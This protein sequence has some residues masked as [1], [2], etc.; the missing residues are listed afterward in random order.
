MKQRILL[1]HDEGR[2]T[3]YQFHGMRY[4][5]VRRG[6]DRRRPRETRARGALQLNRSRHEPLSLSF[7]GARSKKIVR[8]VSV[9]LERDKLISETLESTANCLV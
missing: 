7:I 8:G 9:V 6:S 5:L 1:A 4:K 3:E 2:S